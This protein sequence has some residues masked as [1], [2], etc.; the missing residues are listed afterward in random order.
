MEQKNWQL[1]SEELEAAAKNNRYSNYNN[2]ASFKMHSII[3]KIL[4]KR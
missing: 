3:V 1:A 4:K 2:S